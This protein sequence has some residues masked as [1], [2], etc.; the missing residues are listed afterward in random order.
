MYGNNSATK[1]NE[2]TA[3]MRESQFQCVD[4]INNTGIA[5]T[6]D[7][8]DAYSI[9]PP[10]K[11]EV[12]N[13]LLYKALHKTY[14]YKTIAVDAPKYNSFKV[15]K[16]RIKLSFENMKMGLYSYGKLKN[17]EIAE[18][19]KTFYPA[20]AKIIKHKKILVLSDKVPNPVAVRYAWKNCG[21][22]TLFSNS[23]LP[24]SSFRTDNWNQ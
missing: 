6:M 18:T 8:G 17:Y 20:T 2:N 13:R 11:K 5:I 22:R 16:Q 1:K 24:V 14:G 3:F 9:H 7:I 12:A 21:V 4:L 19:D 15:E 10:N 23:L